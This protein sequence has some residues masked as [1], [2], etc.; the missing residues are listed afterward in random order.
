MAV[1]SVI[2]HKMDALLHSLSIGSVTLATCSSHIRDVP[3][4]G[5]EGSV[6]PELSEG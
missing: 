6:H 4:A 1:C 5:V 3:L 2:P